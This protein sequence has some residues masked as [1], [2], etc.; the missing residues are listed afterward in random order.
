MPGRRSR[1]GKEEDEAVIVERLGRG[2]VGQ[3]LNSAFS[4]GENRSAYYAGK[5]TGGT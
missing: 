4:S 1:S 5:D 2:T 3:M